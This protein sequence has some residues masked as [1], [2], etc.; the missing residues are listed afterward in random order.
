[1]MK[2]KRWTMADLEKLRPG[3]VDLGVKKQP[4]A[5]RKQRYAK[6][7]QSPEKKELGHTIAMICQN[8]GFELATELRF[9]KRLFRFDW[10]IPSLMIAIEYEGINSRK[11]GHLTIGGYT[12]N[13]TKYNLAARHGWKLLRY[14]MKNYKE[15]GADLLHL[16]ENS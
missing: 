13:C 9:S 10:A 11:S 16:I 15:A 4:A 7:K 8:G 5:V 3:M 1:M 14:T 2:G 6:S 12:S